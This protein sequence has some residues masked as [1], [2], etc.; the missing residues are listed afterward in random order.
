MTFLFSRS[1][2]ND[3]LIEPDEEANRARIQAAIDRA[4]QIPEVVIP[5]RHEMKQFPA[6]E[7][8]NENAA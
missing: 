1:P 4:I 5:Q 2:K 8:A 7:N 6:R 3:N